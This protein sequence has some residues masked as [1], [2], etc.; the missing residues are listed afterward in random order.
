MEITFIAGEM[1]FEGS[2]AWRG[3][4]PSPQVPP[5]LC[6]E[7]SPQDGNSEGDGGCLSPELRVPPG[8]AEGA[9]AH[10][11]VLPTLSFLPA[12]F[13]VEIPTFG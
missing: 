10:S 12:S 7:V 3:G 8:G 6:L 4:V 1:I 9:A 13:G 5:S 2:R 11:D